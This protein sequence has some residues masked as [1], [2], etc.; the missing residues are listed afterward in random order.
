MMTKSPFRVIV[1][2]TFLCLVCIWLGLIVSTMLNLPPSF[3]IV[4]FSTLLWLLTR[5][6]SGR[7]S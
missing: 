7:K 5:L 2:S 6:I 4:T 1:V 3:V